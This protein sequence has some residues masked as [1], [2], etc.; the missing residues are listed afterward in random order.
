[1]FHPL[2]FR[3]HWGAELEVIALGRSFLERG[4]NIFKE[5]LNSPV[6]HRDLTLD[7]SDL[8]ELEP[9][10]M[11]L[12]FVIFKKTPFLFLCGFCCFV[13][14]FFWGFFDDDDER[15]VFQTWSENFRR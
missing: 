3:S 5:I 9:T 15:L 12:A 8:Y 14:G 11:T 13:F 6:E 1:M 7:D 4:Q 10:Q 2:Q